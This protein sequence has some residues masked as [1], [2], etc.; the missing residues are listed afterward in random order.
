MQHFQAPQGLSLEVKRTKLLQEIFHE[1]KDFYQVL[2]ELEKLGPNLKG[3]GMT[4][5]KE[6]LQSLVDDGLVQG[7]KIGASN[8]FWS[9]PSQRGTIVELF[10][11]QDGSY[12]DQCMP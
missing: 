9:F 10:T 5:F 6:V 8:F 11:S 4:I 1:S 7:D 2:K 3:I 12:T